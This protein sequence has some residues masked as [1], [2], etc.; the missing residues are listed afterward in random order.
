MSKK[1]LEKNITFTKNLLTATD[2]NFSTD[3]I[4]ELVGVSEAFVL[5]VKR[6]LNL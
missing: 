5:D 4:A 1:E 2:F 3:K 6:D